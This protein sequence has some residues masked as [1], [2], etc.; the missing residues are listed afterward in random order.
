MT[1]LTNS[2]RVAITTAIKNKQIHLA[3]G[4]GLE[5]WDTVPPVET[6]GIFGLTAE[7]G[8]NLITSVE[9]AIPDANG[10]IE[11]PFF[12]GT[13][14]QKF[15][16]SEHPT[17]Y[18]YMDFLCHPLAAVDATIREIGIMLDTILLSP[19]LEYSEPFDIVEPGSLLVIEYLNTKI[20][21]V[22]GKSE[23]FE[24]VLSL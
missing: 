17:S 11:S 13:G 18:L 22:D 14:T 12:N 15:S 16:L 9:Y 8:R 6:V 24:F 19:N 1:T 20:V 23:R 7:L 5:A 21:R 2:G 4:S 3:W 10:P